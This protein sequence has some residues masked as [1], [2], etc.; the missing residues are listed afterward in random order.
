VRILQPPPDLPKKIRFLDV[1][2]TV[3]SFGRFQES[4][5]QARSVEHR[6]SELLG[7]ER[8]SEIRTSLTLRKVASASSSVGGLEQGPCM[9]EP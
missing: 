6:A 1:F 3:A 4:F 5:R 9:P 7:N 8:F 2:G